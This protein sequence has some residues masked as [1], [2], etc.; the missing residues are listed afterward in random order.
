MSQIIVCF[1]DR[2]CPDRDIAAVV[3]DK[4]G[5]GMYLGCENE[6]IRIAGW[7]RVA[8]TGETICPECSKIIQQ[9]L[10]QE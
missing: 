8:E 6:A 2:C 10:V 5:R 9:E 3:N 1:C 7:L 4:R